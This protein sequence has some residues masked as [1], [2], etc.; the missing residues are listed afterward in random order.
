[1]AS[2]R[3]AFTMVNFSFGYWFVVFVFLWV[4]LSAAA[5]Y[6]V[7]VVEVIVVQVANLSLYAIA[8]IVFNASKA[9]TNADIENQVWT[10]FG[11]DFE[12]DF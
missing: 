9:E 2:C 7:L 5:L 12:S 8:L 10:Y 4:I 1:M 3:N 11:C 6:V